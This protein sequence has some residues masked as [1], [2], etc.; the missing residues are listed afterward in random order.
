MTGG[1]AKDMMGRFMED[2]LKITVAIR[3]N[4]AKISILITKAIGTGD[5]I[6]HQDQ[7]IIFVSLSTIKTKVNKAAKPQR[8]IL[9]LFM[10]KED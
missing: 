6:H 9:E 8:L 4:T 10:E 7:A 1:A 5:R 3:I 2:Y